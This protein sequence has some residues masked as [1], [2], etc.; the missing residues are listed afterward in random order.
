MNVVLIGGGTGT[1]VV[2]NSLKK[3]KDIKLSVIVSMMDDGGSNAV[4]RDVF[5]ILPLSDVRK[6]I[7]AMSNYENDVVFR[8]LFTY[9]FDKG[10]GLKGH[11]LGNLMMIGLSNITGSEEEAIDS[12]VKIFNID[13][14]IIPV[15]LESTR[16]EALY[17]DGTKIN[18]EHY[19]DES[20]N[21]SKIKRLS[22]SKKVK[23]NPRAIKVIKD[24]DYIIIGPGD[25]YT[26][27]IPNLLVDGMSKAIKNSKAKLIYITNLMSKTGETTG[28]TQKDITE[29][30][31]KHIKR[32][33]DYI[34][35]N[36]GHIDPKI[37]KIYM[38]TE[39]QHILKDN[40]GKKDYII[41]RDLVDN[42]IIIKDKGDQ[43]RRSL[44]RHSPEKL[45]KELYS[46]LRGGLFQ[47]I[48]QVFLSSLH[49]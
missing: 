29:E 24:A 19:I 49:N 32:D 48:S 10:E 15:T 17:N 34:L 46:I 38:E 31:I 43:H 21:N 3:Y 28:M 35:V 1:S 47:S 16:L 33:L 12:L 2:I 20:I 26:T 36:N 39:G 7:I 11:T 22:L 4:V 5:G 44:I 27:I 42:E 6:S 37:I 13:G 9:R 41:R 14:D 30:I 25:L 8:Q 40:L 18:G 23:A 45:G